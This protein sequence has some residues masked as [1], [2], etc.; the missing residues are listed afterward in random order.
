MGIVKTTAIIMPAF[1]E[2]KN[3]KQLIIRIKEILSSD[4]EL[5]VINDGSTDSTP[6]ILNETNTNHINLGSNSGYGVAIQTGI[7]Y[8]LRNNFEY[9]VL[10]D[11]DGQHNPEDIPTLL[12]VI[13]NK[14]A[15]LALGSRFVEDT[16]Y[17]GS[18]FRRLGE[19]LFS[20]LIYCLDGIKIHD[21][22][23]GFQAFDKKVQEIYASEMFPVDYPD[24]DMLL[25][26]SYYNLKIKEVPV[27]MSVNTEKSM[28]SGIKRIVYYIYK[29]LVSI[30][31]VVS[32]KKEIERRITYGP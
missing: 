17:G 5:V 28:H 3:I 4:A 24:A 2:E 15:D 25:L 16:G 6:Q 12:N 20:F 8:A 29:M 30:L 1:N 14:E 19:S 10:I 22:T 11:A 26:L 7:K 27:K 23:S 9:V 31:V 32:Y 21:P 18:I 13:K